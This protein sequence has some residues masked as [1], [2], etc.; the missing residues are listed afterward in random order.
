MR[1]EADRV[2]Q[3]APRKLQ[4]DGPPGLSSGECCNSHVPPRPQP[5]AEGAAHTG[6]DHPD[7]VRRHAEDVRDFLGGVAH[8][9]RLVL[10]SQ[11]VAVPIRALTVRLARLTMITGRDLT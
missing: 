11:P 10:H 6:R 5:G 3:L 1:P 8:P 4:S 2:E 9:S 7:A